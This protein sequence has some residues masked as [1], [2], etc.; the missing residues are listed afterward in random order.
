MT[1]HFEEA[2]RFI[3]EALRKGHILVHC[4]AGISRVTREV[5]LVNHFRDGLFDENGR[6]DF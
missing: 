3:E 4:A 1:P 5:F 2:Y 6:D